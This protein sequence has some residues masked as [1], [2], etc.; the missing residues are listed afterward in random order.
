MDVRLI[1]RGLEKPH[2]IEVEESTQTATY[3]KFTAKPLEKGFGH[4]IGNS[5]RRILLS[6]IPGAA[7]T[8]V[9]IE[10]VEHE[11]AVVPGVIEDVT[12]IILNLKA[13]RLK[14]KGSGVRTLSLEVTGPCEVKASMLKAPDDVE[15][16]TPDSTIATIDQ[17]GFKL[18]LKVVA[19]VG[20]GFLTA[21]EVKAKQDE[22]GESRIGLIP[23]DALFS[24]VRKCAYSVETTRVRQRTD[25]DKLVMEITTDGS[26]MPEDAL[27]YA[28]RIFTDYLNVFIGFDEAPEVEETSETKEDEK[29]KKLLGIPVDELELSVRS[30]NCLKA[31]NLHV[32]GELVIRTDQEMLKYRNFGKKSLQEI[33]EKLV[34]YNLSLGM[35]DKAHLVASSGG[36]QR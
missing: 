26:I 27:G 29:L 32:L 1:T 13:L 34:Q 16:L 7:I 5:L 22:A 10:G 28:A 4:T 12:E 31:A 23:V 24:P 6:S 33:K 20:L 9:E 18:S 2:R 8:A 19:S 15:I 11:F 21:E 30:A 36:D 3:G 25:Y 35:K 17:P 14:I